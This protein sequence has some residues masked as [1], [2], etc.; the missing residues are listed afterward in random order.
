[1]GEGNF[2][3]INISHGSSMIKNESEKLEPTTPK[4]A[5]EKEGLDNLSKR[6][7]KYSHFKNKPKNQSNNNKIK[8]D[9]T[10]IILYMNNYSEEMLKFI[11]SIRKRPETFVQYIDNIINNNIQKLNDDIYIISKN[12]EEKVK[13]MEDYLIVFEQIK[14]I[15]KEFIDSKKS[16]NLEE[17]KYNEELEIILDEA[18][19]NHN[20]IKNYNYNQILKYKKNRN[21]I[22]LDLSDDKIA[23]LILEKRK[24][25]KNKY[26]ESFFKLNVIRDIEINILIQISMELF[27]NPHYDEESMLKGIIFNPKYKNFAVSWA[28]EINRNFISISCFA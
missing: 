9:N 5:I 25:L 27:Y 4:I 22:F 10:N 7:R 24:Q 28:N 3:F 1:M 8:D 6:N 26:P 15:M 14:R 11:N 16:E 13:L 19:D 2:I 18:D 23:N 12:I 17:L 21:N 20:N